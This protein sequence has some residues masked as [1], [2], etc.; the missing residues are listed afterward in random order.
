MKGVLNNY[1]GKAGI[2]QA[3]PSKLKHKVP[4]LGSPLPCEP[5]LGASAAGSPR[6]VTQPGCGLQAS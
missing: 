4:F 3:V 6:Q 1:A 2:D 5:L